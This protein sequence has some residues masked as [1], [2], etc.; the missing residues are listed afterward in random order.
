M[1]GIKK[2]LACNLMDSYRDLYSC[3][4]LLLAWKEFEKEKVGLLFKGKPTF[5]SVYAKDLLGNK[6]DERLFKTS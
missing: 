4:L 5:C 1:R 3:T 6:E 2:L